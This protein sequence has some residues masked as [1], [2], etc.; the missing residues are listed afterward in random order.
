MAQ[1]FHKTAE[2]R[3]RHRCEDKLQALHQAIELFLTI[4]RRKSWSEPLGS[5][6]QHALLRTWAGVDAA[7]PSPHRGDSLSLS[8]SR[9]KRGHSFTGMRRNVR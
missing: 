7:A 6:K 8:W 9:P 2:L 1:L 4:D 5:R 3:E